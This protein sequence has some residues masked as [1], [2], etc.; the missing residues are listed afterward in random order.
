MCARIL[1]DQRAR[2]SVSIAHEP[3]GAGAI[4]T[5]VSFVQLRRMSR[6][7]PHS[8]VLARNFGVLSFPFTTKSTRQR[9][10]VFYWTWHHFT[11]SLCLIQPNHF[12]HVMPYTISMSLLPTRNTPSFVA[13]AVTVALTHI[14]AIPSYERRA[15]TW[16][17][18]AP[19]TTRYPCPRSGPKTGTAHSQSPQHGQA[20][21]GTPSLAYLV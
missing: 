4:A 9:N 20:Q 5:G 3:H 19:A 17:T 13:V 18:H 10:N 14:F 7:A 2:L 12:N 6:D 8:F 1:R 16:Q 15:E 11:D 21:P